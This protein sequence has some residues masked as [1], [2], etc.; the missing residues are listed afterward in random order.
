MYYRPL[1]HIFRTGEQKILL[2]LSQ[3]NVVGLAAGG[4]L[5][6]LLLQ[7]FAF[8]PLLPTAAVCL[9]SGAGVT[10]RYRG[11]PIYLHLYRAARHTLRHAVRPGAFDI[12]TTTFYRADPAEGPLL[13]PALE[14]DPALPA[15]AD[16]GRADHLTG[17]GRFAA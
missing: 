14:A 2:G 10:F 12:D 6:M 17:K 16:Q 7:R 11:W 13:L 8:L 4:F 9:L 15:G 3:A 1:R 5:A